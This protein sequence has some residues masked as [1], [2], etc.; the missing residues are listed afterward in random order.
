[1]RSYADLALGRRRVGDAASDRCRY[2]PQSLRRAR[3]LDRRAYATNV[4]LIFIDLVVGLVLLTCCVFG[5]SKL[6]VGWLAL[7]VY[8]ALGL[9]RQ[10]VN[11]CRCAAAAYD[12]R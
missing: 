11:S 6:F 7:H 1:V 9:Y 4:L 12:R 2:R 8:L 3:E 5:D 10:F